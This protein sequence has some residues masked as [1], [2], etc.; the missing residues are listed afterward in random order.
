MGGQEANWRKTRPVEDPYLE[1]LNAMFN[2]T[3]SDDLNEDR[4]LSNTKL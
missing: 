1:G 4:D 2:A 3:T